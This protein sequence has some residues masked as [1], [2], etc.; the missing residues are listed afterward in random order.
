VAPSSG[1]GNA[2]RASG[3]VVS[4]QGYGGTA[5]VS[6]DGRTITTGEFGA[7]CPAK[8]KAVARETATRVALFLQLST[9]RNPPSCPNAAAAIIPAQNVRLRAPLGSRKLV[10][11]RTGRPTGVD[12]RPVH[13]APHSSPGQRSP[14]RADPGSGPGQGAKPRPGWMTGVQNPQNSPEMLST[15]QLIAI[16]ESSPQPG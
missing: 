13:S 3:Q 1:C 5:I 16:A 12:Q 6:T 2:S 7:S 15:Q 8:V 14:S 9:P 11:G 10:N 4:C